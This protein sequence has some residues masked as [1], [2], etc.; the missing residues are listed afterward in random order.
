[1]NNDDAVALAKLA[2]K[3]SLALLTSTRA[4]DPSL[5]QAA[6]DTTLTSLGLNLDHA[7]RDRLGAQLVQS[8]WLASVCLDLL[9]QR[10][11]MSADE[12]MQRLA[13]RIAE[14]NGE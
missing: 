12:T 13:L 6:I 9:A 4:A 8:A 5:Q 1:M 7:E 10:A 11:D 2:T 14:L 3:N